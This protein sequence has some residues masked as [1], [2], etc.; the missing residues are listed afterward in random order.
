MFCYKLLSRNREKTKIDL[1]LHAFKGGALLLSQLDSAAAAAATPRYFLS[2]NLLLFC[3][4]HHQLPPPAP[5][6]PSHRTRSI[7]RWTAAP[8]PLTTLQV[9][10]GINPPTPQC[11]PPSHLT[12]KR[13]TPLSSVREERGG[14]RERERGAVQPRE[15]T[16]R[17]G[18]GA[19]SKTASQYLYI[20]RQGSRTEGEAECFG[21]QSG[22]GGGERGG[23]ERGRRG[24]PTLP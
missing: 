20:Q 6:L 23:E 17:R 11:S 1:Y 7:R 22:G 5:L 10:S 19:S 18:D 15:C 4:H 13:S 12:G 24:R 14:E 9:V 8:P 21:P 3:H 2:L 16:P